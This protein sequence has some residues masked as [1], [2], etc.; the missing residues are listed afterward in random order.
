MFCS[1]GPKV[2]TFKGQSGASPPQVNSPRCL[3]NRHLYMRSAIHQLARIAK[4]YYCFRPP[5]SAPSWRF[6]PSQT[7]PGR[8]AA[9][10]DTG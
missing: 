7:D 9:L 8:A 6:A 3:R 10:A 1:S 4:Y 2:K 5:D